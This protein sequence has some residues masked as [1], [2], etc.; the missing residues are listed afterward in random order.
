VALAYYAAPGAARGGDRPGRAARRRQLHG[1]ALAALTTA[2]GACTRYQPVPGGAVPPETE[3]R[4]QLTDLAAATLAASLGEGVVAVEGRVRARTD[5]SLVLVATGTV[6][7]NGDSQSWSGEPVRLALRDVARIETRR[8]D[9]PR[10]ALTAAAIVAG[11]VL[12]G[13][14]LGGSSFLGSGRGG[15]RPQQ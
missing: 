15:S 8:T 10:T 3:V 1:L 12:L 13:A 5:S 11:A 2:A 9:K 7:R 4:V 14:S 6:Q